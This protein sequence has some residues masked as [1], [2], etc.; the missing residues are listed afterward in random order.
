MSSLAVATALRQGAGEVVIANRTRRP[1]RAAGREVRRERDQAW[2]TCRPRSRPPTW[3]SP[4]PGAAGHVLSRATVS[5][6]QRLRTDLAG[7]R[8]GTRHARAA[9]P[10]A[11][12]RR[13]DRGGRRCPACTPDRPGGDRRRERAAGIRRP[14]SRPW[15]ATRTSPRC[16]RSWRRSWPVVPE[17][18]AGR[19]RRADGRRAAREGRDG[20]GVRAGQAGPPAR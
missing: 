3:W 16:A 14:V 10:G 1:R 12:P 19:E 18:R 13:R 15:R 8:T 17:G 11:A 6:A 7:R 5:Q 20:R 4:A 9:R 2:P